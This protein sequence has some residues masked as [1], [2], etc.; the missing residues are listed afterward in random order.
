M[1][2]FLII[3]AFALLSC[4]EKHLN[5]STLFKDLEDQETVRIILSDYKLD[6]IPSDIT[7]LKKV[8]DLTILAS[9]SDWVIY[10]PLSVIAQ[11]IDM[12]PF[13]NLPNEISNL[14]QL[15]ALR[16]S[17]ANIKNLPEGFTNLKHLEYLDVS[18]NKLDVTSEVSTLKKA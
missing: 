11:Q 7:N 15:Q 16:I 12:P 14:T 13:H 9:N 18:M 8:R 6:E 3:F 10:P 4:S 2:V 1:K 5:D 17:G